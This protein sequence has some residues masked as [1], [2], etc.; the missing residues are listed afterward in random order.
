MVARLFQITS[1]SIAEDPKS[2]S[3]LYPF[4]YFCFEVKSFFVI[5]GKV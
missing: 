4:L 5:Y 1:V 3:L 2:S